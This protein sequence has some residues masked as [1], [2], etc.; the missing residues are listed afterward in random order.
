MYRIILPLVLT[1]FLTGCTLKLDM[2]WTEDKVVTKVTM[3]SY[4]PY[5]YVHT[6]PPDN[7][8]PPPNIIRS[9]KDRPS[10]YDEKELE[11]YA[12]SLVEYHGYLER[13][14]GSMEDRDGKAMIS[15]DNEKCLQELLTLINITSPPARPQ[16]PTYSNVEK[17]TGSSLMVTYLND[18]DRWIEELE[19]HHQ[20]ATYKYNDHMYKL[21]EVCG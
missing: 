7:L 14:I 18:L 19:K 8:L 3:D 16:P 21:K 20:S 2:P 1:L 12:D 9:T 5:S 6:N 10:Y 4:A 17:A 11:A 15:V 13:Y